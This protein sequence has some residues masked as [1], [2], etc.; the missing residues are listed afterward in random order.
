MEEIKIS[1]S[2]YIKSFNSFDYTQNHK[3]VNQYLNCIIKD[4]NSS[5][6][7]EYIDNL[8]SDVFLQDK[9]LFIYILFSVN[10]PISFAIFSKISNTFAKLDLIYTAYEYTKLGFATIMLRTCAIN[11]L[12]NKVNQI[13][14]IK[15]GKNEIIE[16]L[17]SS[18]SKVDGV[19]CSQ[20]DN[21][22]KFNVE[23]I[24]KND[25]LSKIK[26]FVIK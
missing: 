12:Q 8:N 22:I 10:Q 14:Y 3:L 17:L 2:V 21:Q 4:Y 13:L 26:E 9:K 20:I 24:N 11:L 19:E 1:N 6:A 15:N 16:N 23:K 25:I 5:I 18:F 7:I